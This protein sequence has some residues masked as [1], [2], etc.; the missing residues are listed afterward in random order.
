MALIACLG[1][2]SLVWDPRELPIKREW[3]LD[4]PLIKVELARQ[5]SDGRIT[6]V[7]HEA[8][9][10]VRSLWA[11]MD[12]SELVAACEALR[13]REG[14]PKNDIAAIGSWQHGGPSPNLIERLPEWAASRGIDAVVW[15]NLPAKFDGAKGSA[16]NCEQVINYLSELTGR[17]RDSAEQYIRFA[18]RQIDTQYRRKIEAVLH[19]TPK[20]ANQP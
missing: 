3:F 8:A 14:I 5:S 15:T 2:G 20:D 4:G 10:S 19:W 11:L 9:W 12:H 18:P 1:W 13:L 16:P 17:V 7:L 6:L